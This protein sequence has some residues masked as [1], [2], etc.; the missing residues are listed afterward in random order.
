MAPIQ[1][2]VSNHEKIV[3]QLQ[4]KSTRIYEKSARAHYLNISA[5][6]KACGIIYAISKVK[7][8]DNPLEPILLNVIRKG[9]H[10]TEKNSAKEKQTVQI[11]GDDNRNQLADAIIL[12]SHGSSKKF[13][14]SRVGNGEENLPSESALRQMLYERSKKGLPSTNWVE[15]VMYQANC[16]K[17]SLEYDKIVP[18]FVHGFQVKINIIY[19]FQY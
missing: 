8:P 6:C 1:E 19:S 14:E 17:D 4:V 7:K 3:L 2:A 5:A 15:N 12:E 18:G 10:D 13:L 11:R 16:L 9:E